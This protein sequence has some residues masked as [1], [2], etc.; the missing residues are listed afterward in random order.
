MSKWR[1]FTII[2]TESRLCLGYVWNVCYLW[3]NAC[4]LG[5][6]FWHTVKYTY[7]KNRSTLMNHVSSRA[8]IRSIVNNFTRRVS[9]FAYLNTVLYSLQQYVIPKDWQ[10]PKIEIGY[11]TEKRLTYAELKRDTV[12]SEGVTEQEHRSNSPKRINY[13]FNYINQLPS[14][15]TH[16]T[17]DQSNR[18]IVYR[19]HFVV[20]GI[21]LQQR[22]RKAIEDG[23]FYRYSRLWIGEPL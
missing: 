9:W 13:V 16:P 21:I 15:S 14:N 3:Q 17:S 2:C 1:T 8:I 4:L 23:N 19:G 22:D 12:S 11:K 6:S 10:P 7:I 18:P 5:Q 20:Q